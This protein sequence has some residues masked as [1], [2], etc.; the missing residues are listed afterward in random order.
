MDTTITLKEAMHS[1][2]LVLNE[3]YK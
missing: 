2:G 1:L 3:A